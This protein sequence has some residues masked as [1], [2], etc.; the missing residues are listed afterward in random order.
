MPNEWH[1]LPAAEGRAANQRTGCSGLSGMS[2]LGMQ[3]PRPAAPGCRFE[4]RS[5]GSLESLLWKRCIYS[6]TVSTLKIPIGIQNKAHI[7][8]FNCIAFNC[9]QETTSSK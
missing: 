3:G 7:Y 1:E 8:W 5:M 9:I 4:S 6:A 2:L